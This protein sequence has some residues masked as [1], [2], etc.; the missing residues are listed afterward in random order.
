MKEVQCTIATQVNVHR[1]VARLNGMKKTKVL[2]IIPHTIMPHAG[3]GLYPLNVESYKIIYEGPTEADQ[4]E[5]LL[6]KAK[7]R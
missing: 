5:E 1:E 2:F 4:I 6:E 7:K 3:R